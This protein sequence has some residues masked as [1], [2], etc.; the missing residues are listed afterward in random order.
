MA[1]GR[2]TKPHRQSW[3]DK[4][5]DGLY[6]CPDGRW[7]CWVKGKDT[8]FTEPDER[9]AIARFR[10]LTGQ[11]EQVIVPI[12]PKRIRDLADMAKAGGTH[13]LIEGDLWAYVREELLDRPA[14]V[15]KM[16]GI[17][18]LANLAH[19]DLPKPPLKLNALLEIYQT[20]ADVKADTKREAGKTFEDFMAITGAKTLADLTT[21]TLSLY[22]DTIKQRVSSPGTIQAYFGRVKWIIAFAK[23]EGQDAAQIDAALSRMAVLKA[24]K[25]KRVHQPTPVSREAFHKLYTTAAMSFPDWQ[26]RL[27]VMLNLCLHFDEAL[28]LEWT[29][30]DLDAGTFCTKRNKRGR[31]IRA[32]TLWPETIAML[33]AIPHTGS[34]FVFVSTH[35]TRF[36]AKGQWKT[37]HKLR[38]AAGCPNAQMDDVR[39]G[40][41]S[42]ACAAP[43]V[44]EKYARLMAGHRSHGLQDNYVARNPAIVK[45]ACD[46]VYQTYGTLPSVP[47]D[48]KG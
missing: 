28:D 46:A 4:S 15:A 23:T 9:R 22:R 36:N 38:Q 44:D 30:F 6:K 2:R 42:A 17:P 12:Q 43:G 35:G 37:W 19:M 13:G 14:W 26:P 47:A 32:A 34:P 25:D 18:E 5:V 33:R 20:H 29:D 11:P 3:D 7:R 21:E 8:K 24:P 31:V 10:Q 48:Q 40:A 16:V 27:L 41:Y 39:D 1:M 45:S